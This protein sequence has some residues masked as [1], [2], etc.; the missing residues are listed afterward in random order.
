M[1]AEDAAAGEAVDEVGGGRLECCSGAA[2]VAVTAPDTAFVAVSDAAE[3]ADPADPA[4]SPGPVDTDTDGERTVPHRPAASSAAQPAATASA[5]ITVSRTVRP[6]QPPP[7]VSASGPASASPAVACSSTAIRSPSARLRALWSRSPGA[8]AVR[9]VPAAPGAP[10]PAAELCALPVRRTP[11][12]SARDS[13]HCR[14]WWPIVPRSWAKAI[15]PA[16]PGHNTGGS[17]PGEAV[18]GRFGGAAPDGAN[19]HAG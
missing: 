7:L 4:D 5:A 18:A 13:R 9:V 16:R 19:D 8:P 15:A 10:V 1:G 6:R 11:P 14:G 2:G 17:I 3:P 12:G